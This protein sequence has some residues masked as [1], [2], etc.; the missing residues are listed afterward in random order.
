MDFPY[1]LYKIVLRNREIGYS[2]PYFYIHIQKRKLFMKQHQAFVHKSSCTFLIYLYHFPSYKTNR[3]RSCAV[4][5]TLQLH[6]KKCKLSSTRRV[7]HAQ[8]G[9]FPVASQCNRSEISLFWTFCCRP[10]ID[11]IVFV[12]IFYI[13]DFYY[14]YIFMYYEK[15]K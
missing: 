1:L 9:A 8:A 3:G 13:N 2:D 15:I 14:I 12:Y 10:P 11:T 7:S 6:Y 5:D 4:C